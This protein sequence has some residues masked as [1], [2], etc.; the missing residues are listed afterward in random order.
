ME[1]ARTKLA[2]L[3]QHG[4]L[5]QRYGARIRILGQRELVTPEVLKAVDDAVAM[6]EGN[7]G[8]VLNVC[9][10]YTSR[11]EITAAVR[12]TVEEFVGDGGEGEVDFIA[13]AR[14]EGGDGRKRGFSE[15]TIERRLSTLR[16]ESASPAP[17]AAG[18]R[19]QE[20]ST[21]DT[22]ST[23]GDSLHPSSAAAA[24]APS[25][26]PS[27]TNDQPSQQ[28]PTTNGH[29]SASPSSFSSSTTLNHE[30]SASSHSSP[31][32][33]PPI[34]ALT[35]PPR[36][37]LHDAPNPES[38]TAA[39]LSRRM[40][41]HPAPPPDLLIRTSGVERLSDFML[42]QCHEST[43]IRFLTCLWPEFGLLQFLPVLVE[44]QWWVRNGGGVG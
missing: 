26:Q 23:N 5:L 28:P 2:Q 32:S 20:E 1:M 39:H 12:G 10:P 14:R 30:H 37:Q 33:S 19:R 13:G 22:A 4:E 9:F 21:Q 24:G 31:A 8:A 35:E 42:W 34:S 3:S 38:I 16:E 6:T 25:Q 40:Y 7:S 43:C 41:T 27:T 36:Q 11:D 18:R 17:D 15:R 29:L 44:W